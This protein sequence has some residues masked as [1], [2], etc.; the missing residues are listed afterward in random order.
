VT[1]VLPSRS[2]SAPDAG[3]LFCR[4]VDGP[5]ELAVHHRMRTAVFVNEQGLFAPDDRDVHD[6]DP[7]TVHVLGSVGAEPAG[8]VRLYPLGGSAWKGDRLAV[9]PPYRRSRIAGRLVRFAVAT[10]A[11]R[12]GTRMDALVQTANVRFF[13]SLGWSAVGE[14]HDLLGL[15]HQPMTIALR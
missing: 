14:P 5:D 1:D 11:E 9:L 2:S 13:L 15:P 7:V 3:L 8:A 6:D 10:A 4:A 12:G